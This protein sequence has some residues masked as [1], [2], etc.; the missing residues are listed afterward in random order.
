MESCTIKSNTHGITLILDSEI[1]FE[2]LVKDICTKFATAKDFFGDASL[3]LTISGRELSNQEVAVI[4]E[5]IELNSSIHIILIEEDNQLKDIRMQG[6]IDRFYFDQIYE[7]ARIVTGSIK[8]D[9][10]FETEQSLVVL[11]DIK[12]GATVKAGGNVIIYGALLGEVHAGYPNEDACYIIAG[13]YDGRE[14][15]IGTHTGSCEVAKSKRSL[16]RKNE[17][18][19]EALAIA[20]YDDTL[21]CEPINRGIFKEH[22]T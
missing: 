8:S 13:C 9:T 22:L 19:S 16:F 14:V 7:N 2:H 15:S 11:G 1:S 3:I 12:D 18:H 10:V 20:V 21:T 17:N 5:A 6:K 4:V